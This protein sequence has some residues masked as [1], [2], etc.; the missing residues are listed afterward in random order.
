MNMIWMT[1][2][3]SPG[4]TDLIQKHRQIQIIHFNPA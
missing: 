4:K 3:N 2:M 1:V